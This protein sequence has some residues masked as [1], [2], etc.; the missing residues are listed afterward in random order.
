M[1]LTVTVTIATR[2]QL[3][4]ILERIREDVALCAAP[5]AWGPRGGIHTI[6]DANG[7][8]VGAWEIATRAN[9]CGLRARPTCWADL[10]PPP[11]GAT[12]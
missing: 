8:R 4:R 10:A 3:T 9:D 7:N 11:S 5:D 2:D 6:N 12:Q 1:T